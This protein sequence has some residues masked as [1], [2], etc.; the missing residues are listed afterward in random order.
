MSY[1]PITHIR[2]D[3]DIV[4]YGRR[5]LS[6]LRGLGS[7]SQLSAED[8]NITSFDGLQSL[9]LLMELYSGTNQIPGLKV[10]A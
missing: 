6:P 5:Q 7:L 9:R 4:Y 3:A 10:G 1:C 2:L 8:N